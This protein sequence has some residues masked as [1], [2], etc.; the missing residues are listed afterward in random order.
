MAA[1]GWDRSGHGRSTHSSSTSLG[2]IHVT[3]G[4]TCNSD[5]DGWTGPTAAVVVGGAAGR[6]GPRPSELR[7]E[8]E[9]S[10]PVIAV[11]LMGG[12]ELPPPPPPCHQGCLSGRG[13]RGWHWAFFTRPLPQHSHLCPELLASPVCPCKTGSHIL[14]WGVKWG[15]AKSFL[16]RSGRECGGPVRERTGLCWQAA[17]PQPCPC[18]PSGHPDSAR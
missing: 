5:P 11:Q 4:H 7:G 13:R 6:T 1:R 17:S 9:A 3:E 18:R 2:T 15:R 10:G 14:L 8:M 12:L 16:P